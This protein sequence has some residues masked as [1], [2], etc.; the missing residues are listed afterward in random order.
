MLVGSLEVRRE[1]LKLSK[2]LSALGEADI[3][4]DTF[5][6]LTRDEVEAEVEF[7]AAARAE[8]LPPT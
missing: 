4:K 2:A 7:S 1:G 6:R 3:D 8:L 5:D